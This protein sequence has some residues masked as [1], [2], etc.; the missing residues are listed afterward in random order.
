MKRMLFILVLI[1]L[2]DVAEDGFLCKV[3]FCLPNHSAET[4]VTSPYYHPDPNQTPFRHELVFTDLLGS[5][6]D[7]NA[8]PVILRVPSTLQKMYCYHLSSSGGIPF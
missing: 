3:R 6:L 5:L 7:K 4:S 2:V 1:L 8:Q